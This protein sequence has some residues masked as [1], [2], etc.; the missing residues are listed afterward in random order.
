MFPLCLKTYKIEGSLDFSLVIEYEDALDF[1]KSRSR[2]SAAGTL[3]A[4]A[5]AFSG[6]GRGA[7]C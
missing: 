1:V 7:L 6:C 2:R 3:D 4:P 5:G